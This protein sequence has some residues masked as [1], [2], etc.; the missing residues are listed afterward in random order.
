MLLVWW[1]LNSLCVLVLSQGP[2]DGEVAQRVGHRRRQ[3]QNPPQVLDIGCGTLVFPQ[4]QHYLA[5]RSQ[6]WKI[7]LLTP[8]RLV[9]ANRLKLV[10]VSPMMSGISGPIRQPSPRNAWL[11]APAP[12]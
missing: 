4:M 11:F 10:A 8:L 9:E 5:R 1:R 7:H 6:Q 2:R 3:Q 12:N